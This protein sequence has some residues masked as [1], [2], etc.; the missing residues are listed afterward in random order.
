MSDSFVRKGL[1]ATMRKLGL[2]D[3]APSGHF[4]SPDRRPRRRWPSMILGYGPRNRACRPASTS[5]TLVIAT[6]WKPSS[7][8]LSRIS[9][10]R[11]PVLAA[12]GKYCH[13]Q[14][15]VRMAGCQGLVRAAA[16]MATRA[17]DRSGFGPLVFADGRREHPLSGGDDAHHMHRAV[18]GVVPAQFGLRHRSSGPGESPGRAAGRVRCARSGRRAVHRF[19]ARL[20]GGE[21]RQPLVVQSAAAA[22]FRSADP[23]P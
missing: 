11:R 1:H 3:Y 5:T 20:Q 6:S 13:G 23:H 14:S 8:D 15:P 9:T 12:S 16:C 2:A 21:R 7:R 17:R 19:F 10:T 22:G 18:S 4:Y